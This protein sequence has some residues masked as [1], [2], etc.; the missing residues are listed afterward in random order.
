MIDIGWL[1]GSQIKLPVSVTRI[2]FAA[3]VLQSLNQ[4]FSLVPQ[5]LLYVNGMNHSRETKRLLPR[6]DTEF[7]TLHV[8]M[9]IKQLKSRMLN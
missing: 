9:N 3:T 1:L 2:G 8:H 6:S 5:L 4:I 7:V